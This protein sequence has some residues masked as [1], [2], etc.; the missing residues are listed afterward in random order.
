MSDAE[1]IDEKQ[2]KSRTRIGTL[3][4]E[5]VELVK[6][7]GGFNLVVT[8]KNGK[9][10]TLGTGPHP[11]LAKFIARKN[12]PS[13]VMLEMSKSEEDTIAKNDVMVAKYEAITQRF[14]DAFAKLE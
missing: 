5:P 4:G 1:T 10:T 9:R 13:M 6:C 7:F 12:A 8:K 14:V 2:V 11:G 3:D